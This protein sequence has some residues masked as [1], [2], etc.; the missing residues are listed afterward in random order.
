MA[1]IE[2]PKVKRP[3]SGHIQYA[4]LLIYGGRL[5]ILRRGGRGLIW[6]HIIKA[7]QRG[8]GPPQARFFFPAF[9]PNMRINEAAISLIYGM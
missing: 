9:L 6:A 3:S 7:P 8:Y 1:S 2:P 5:F 4:P